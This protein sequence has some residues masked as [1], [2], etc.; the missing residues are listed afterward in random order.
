MQNPVTKIQ[1]GGCQ[2]ALVNRSIC[3]V[4]LMTRIQYLELVVEGENQLRMLSCD[5]YV[6]YMTSVHM[7]L[8][9]PPVSLSPH[10]N[11]HTHTRPH[12]FAHMQ[13]TCTQTLKLFKG[14]N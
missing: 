13:H 3:C 9:I 6:H 2:Y 4:S 11:T 7:H 12:T 8:Y 1:K 10:T 14:S 5:C